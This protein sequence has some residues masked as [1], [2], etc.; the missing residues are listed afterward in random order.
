MCLIFTISL[1]GWTCLLSLNPAVLCVSYCKARYSRYNSSP[2]PF[3][4]GT[5]HHISG[6]VLGTCHTMTDTLGKGIPT[7]FFCKEWG[8]LLLEN[9]EESRV[10]LVWL[11][12]QMVLLFHW[13]SSITVGCFQAELAQGRGMYTNAFKTSLDLAGCFTEVLTLTFLHTCTD[14]GIPCISVVCARPHLASKLP[15]HAPLS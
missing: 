9:P 8:K 1:T 4:C 11:V 10:M 13:Q 2:V 14:F 5:T 12:G 6:L 3:L 15:K 7:G